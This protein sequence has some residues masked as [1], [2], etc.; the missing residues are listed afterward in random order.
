MGEIQN[1]NEIFNNALKLHLENKETPLRQLTRKIL[2]EE[3]RYLYANEGLNQR[4]KNIRTYIAEAREMGNIL[5][6]DN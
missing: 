2:N 4:R 3:R 6:E 5:G 1:L